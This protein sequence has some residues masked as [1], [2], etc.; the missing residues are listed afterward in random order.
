MTSKLKV[1]IRFTPCPVDVGDELFPNGI[2]EFNI[3]KL[4]GH[5]QDNPGEYKCEEVAVADYSNDFSTF[6]ELY[7]DVVEISS[8]VVLAEISPG[9]FN[10][11]DGNHRLENARRLGIRSIQ[12]YRL[13]V[14]QHL[15]FLTSKKAYTAYVEYWNSKIDK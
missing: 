13:N 5:I 15:R 12:A 7:L 2:F 3:T 6:N 8:P 9:R 11:I 4:L 10:V 14:T 1:D